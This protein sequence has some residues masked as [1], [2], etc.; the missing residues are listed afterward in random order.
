M[1]QR[2]NFYT[3]HGDALATPNSGGDHPVDP[4]ENV[5]AP[6]ISMTQVYAKAVKGPPTGSCVFLLACCAM[7]T[8]S[9]F[10]PG[11]KMQLGPE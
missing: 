8:R 3:V 9:C 5:G 11:R 4:P 7:S 10:I 6:A 2:E 1:A